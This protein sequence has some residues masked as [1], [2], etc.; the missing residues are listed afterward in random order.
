[1]KFNESCQFYSISGYNLTQSEYRVA[2]YN[3]CELYAKKNPNNIND[4]DVMACV[5]KQKQIRRF[6]KI[7]YCEPPKVLNTNNRCQT[8]AKCLAN[9]SWF[10]VLSDFHLPGK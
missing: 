1:M 4:A 8:V 5:T 6:Y 9:F 3:L 10:I 7:L 2:L